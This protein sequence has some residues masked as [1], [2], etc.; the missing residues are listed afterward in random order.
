MAASTPGVARAL[1]KAMKE[2]GQYAATRP[3]VISYEIPQDD[4]SDLGEIEMPGEAD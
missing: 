1:A 2:Q 3:K 4:W